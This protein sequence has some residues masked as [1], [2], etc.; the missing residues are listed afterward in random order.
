MKILSNIKNW[1]NNIW[2]EGAKAEDR[3]VPSQVRILPPPTLKK[4]LK[5]DRPNNIFTGRGIHGKFF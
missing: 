3:E 1:F 4:G 5:N 2:G